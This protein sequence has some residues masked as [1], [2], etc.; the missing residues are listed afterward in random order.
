MIFDLLICA[1]AGSKGVRNKN[2]R[3]IGKKSLLQKT[4]EMAIKV[5]G[6][7]NVYVS[8]DSVKY[9][10]ISENLGATVP[11]LRPKRLSGSKAKE[12]KVWQHFILNQKKI[13]SNL[14]VLPTTSPFRK[15]SDI[16]K[17]IFLFKS[18]KFDAVIAITESSKNPY[19]NMVEVD[20][21][22]YLHLCKYNSKSDYYYSRQEA[23]F[24]FDITTFFY[25]INCKFIVNNNSLHDGNLGGV[26]VPK[27]RSLDIDTE[28]DLKFANFLNKNN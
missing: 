21:K 7:K 28:I 4:I 17:G 25:I 24:V 16:K 26:I 12:W 18:G 1:R 10:K 22:K 13:N 23:P 2:I 8:T 3:K 19:Y 9:K 27:E 20:R 5:P 15:L 14:I 6:I 11:F